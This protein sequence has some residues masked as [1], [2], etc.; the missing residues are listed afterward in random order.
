MLSIPSSL[1][2]KLSRKAHVSD[3]WR[4]AGENNTFEGG[5][6]RTETDLPYTEYFSGG[7]LFEV[8]NDGNTFL[9]CIFTSRAASPTATPTISARAGAPSPSSIRSRSCRWRTPTTPPCAAARSTTTAF[10]HGI[11]F[12][13]VDGVLIEDCL[14]TGALRETNDIYREKVG[15]MK[16]KGFKILFRGERP[17]PRNEVIPLTEDGIRTYNEVQNVV[18]ATPRSNGSGA[19]PRCTA[20][21]T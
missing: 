2:N 20:W 17:I 3:T 7:N 16:E 11:H 5:Y 12:H 18:F 8:V 21:A 9:D 15:I 14:F 10:G 4:I 13:K 1:K 19:T 6:F